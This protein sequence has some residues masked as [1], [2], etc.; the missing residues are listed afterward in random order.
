QR[1]GLSATCSPLSEAARFLVG[2]GRPCVVAGAADA[3]PLH[4]TVEPLPEGPRFLSALTERLQPELTA[5][6]STLI[7]ANTRALAERLSWALRGKFPQW[8]DRIAVHHSSLAADR[9]REVERDFKDGWLRA[10]VS[11]TSL[12]LGI[13]VGSVDGVV[14]VHPPGGVV[15]L[16]QRV[17]RA[18]HAPGRPRRGLVLTATAAELLEAAVTG[19]GALPPA[20]HEPLHGPA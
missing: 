13:D 16:L 1:V 2:M 17:G 6:R 19:A 5:N 15:R 9:R 14:L 3:L 11:S 4:L 18:G 10:V 8:H 7:F 20:S 12:E